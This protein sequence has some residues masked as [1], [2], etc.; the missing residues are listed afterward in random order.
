MDK[1]V[2][3][4]RTFAHAHRHARVQTFPM[5]LAST[6]QHTRQTGLREQALALAYAKSTLR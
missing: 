3:Y 1:Q 4:T 6:L 5:N 2:T